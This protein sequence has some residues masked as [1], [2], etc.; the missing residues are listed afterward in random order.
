MEVAQQKRDRDLITNQISVMD[1]DGIIQVFEFPRS[2]YITLDVYTHVR[3]AHCSEKFVV[4]KLYLSSEPMRR[5]PKPSIVTCKRVVNAIS[6]VRQ[7][8]ARENVPNAIALFTSQRILK[9][10]LVSAKVVRPLHL[11]STSP[12]P[13]TLC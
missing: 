12:S 4:C 5:L 3:H 2:P 10:F 8:V 9:W 11:G 7:V 6:F 13:I 1:C